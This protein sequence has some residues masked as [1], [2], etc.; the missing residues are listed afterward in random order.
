MDSLKY[1][2]LYV[3][4]IGCVYSRQVCYD[5][6]GCFI[7]TKPFGGTVQRPLAFLPESPGKI[8]TTFTLYSRNNKIDGESIAGKAINDALFFLIKF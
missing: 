2:C 4:F 8:S 3:A 5:G 6:Y 7:D 1:L